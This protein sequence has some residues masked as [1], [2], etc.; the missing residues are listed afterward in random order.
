MADLAWAFHPDNFTYFAQGYSRTTAVMLLR[1][2]AAMCSAPDVDSLRR[3]RY[4]LEAHT[5]THKLR[6][7]GTGSFAFKTGQDYVETSRQRLAATGVKGLPI[8]PLAAGRR[9]E[10]GAFLMP[11][12]KFN[13]TDSEVFSRFCPF[14]LKTSV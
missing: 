1:K 5:P 8:K 12:A 14:V 10:R 11:A 2:I 3:R 6:H 4:F 13:A 9:R 7:G